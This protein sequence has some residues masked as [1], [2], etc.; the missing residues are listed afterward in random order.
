MVHVPN[1]EWNGLFQRP[2]QIARAFADRGALTFYLTPGMRRD[3]A[4]GFTRID[5]GLYVANIS[6]RLLDE[7]EDPIAILA[8]LPERSLLSRLRPRKLVY[9]HMDALEIFGGAA[10]RIR[11][12]HEE[13]VRRADLVTVTAGALAD[14]VRAM[15]IE[16]LL[17]PNGVDFARF[18]STGRTPP[19]LEPIL[20]QRKPLIGYHG[21]LA[22]WFDYDLLLGA[23]RARPEWN[24]VLVGPADFD[25][26]WDLG[27]LEA[28][29]NLHWLGPKEHSELPEYI[30]CF[31]VATIPF[32][33]DAITRA[34]SPIKLFEGFAMGKPVV[35]TALDECRRYRGAFVAESREDF[36]ATLERALRA[37]RDHGSREL[38]RAE[39]SENTWAR[40]VELVWSHL[41]GE[42]SAPAIEPSG[43]ICPSP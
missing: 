17:V 11:R 19:D 9:D 6:S 13:L 41:F 31:D 26:S 24:F 10:R 30:A 21:S 14:E 35:T 16:P 22:R 5:E 33:I 27:A 3:R 39:A 12:D 36:V 18:H 42:G 28:Q 25:D 1:Q 23:A 2:Q 29:E 4:A 40:R 34:C 38:F 37:S 8:W 7:L 43:F 15:G 20:A 32:R